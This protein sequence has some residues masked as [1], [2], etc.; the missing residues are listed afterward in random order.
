MAILFN[1]LRNEGVF[2]QKVENH[3]FA[4]HSP[5]MSGVEQ[6]LTTGAKELGIRPNRRT[7]RWIS[8]T[9]KENEWNDPLCQFPSGEYFAKNLCKPVLFYDS[10][11]RAPKNCL[12]IEI[13]PSALLRH[14]IGKSFPKEHNIQYREVLRRDNNNDNLFVLLST[15][16]Q[17]YIS[18]QNIDVK[19]LY[20]KV[21]YPVPRG[22]DFI[23]PLIRWDH[24]RSHF[25]T[26]Y[27]DYFSP[28]K[29]K[30]VQKYTISTIEDTYLS[31]HKIDGR[32]LYPGVGYVIIAWK[33]MATSLGVNDLNELPV[34]F[35]NVN[36]IQA[37]NLTTDEIVLSCSYSKERHKFTVEVNNT[38]VSTGYLKP[39]ENRNELTVEDKVLSKSDKLFL[40]GNDVYKEFRVRGYDYGPSFQGI[41]RLSADGCEAQVKWTGNLI[42][43]MDSIMQMVLLDEF[44]RFL[45]VPNRIE[46]LKMDPKTL[47]ADRVNSGDYDF[48]AD[49]VFD[50]NIIEVKTNGL[51]MRNIGLAPISRKTTQNGELVLEKY[52]L[53]PYEEKVAIDHELTEKIE[54]YSKQ[55]D[56]CIEKFE[57]SRRELSLIENNIDD[58]NNDLKVDI[59]NNYDSDMSEEE[60]EL[61]ENGEELLKSIKYFYSRNP[62][63]NSRLMSELNLDNDLIQSTL[64]CERFLRSSVD[65]FVENSDLTKK[66]SVLEV[67]TSGQVFFPSIMKLI[68]RT[69]PGSV[70]NNVEYTLCH[71]NRQLLAQNI[72]DSTRLKIIQFDS[73]KCVIPYQQLSPQ[74][75]IVFRDPHISLTS[76][77]KSVLDYELLLRSMETALTDGGF[78]LAFLRDDILDC[79]LR[80]T[81]LRGSA[82]RLNYQKFLSAAEEAGLQ[83]VC[84]KSDS[85][86][87]SSILFRKLDKTLKNET[88]IH[89]TYD[90]LQWLEPLK[91]AMKDQ[92]LDR[93]W[94][95]TDQKLNGITGLVKGLQKEENGWKVRS[96]FIDGRPE[97]LESVLKKAK[98]TDLVQNVFNGKVWGSYR[99]IS[100]PEVIQTRPINSAQ[101]RQ[102]KFGDLSSFKWSLS[103][104]T[105]WPLTRTSNKQTLID[106][107]YSPLNF[108]DVMHATGRLPP[109]DLTQHMSWDDVVLGLEFVGR[110]R[111]TGQRVMGLNSSKALSTDI[112]VDEDFLWSVPDSWSMADAATV[113]CVYA[114]AYYA[115]VIRGRL[116]SGETVLIHAG[117]GGVGQAAINICLS[118]NCRVFTTVGTQEKRQWIRKRFPQMSDSCIAS[119]RDVSFE[120][121]IMKETNGRGVDIILNSLTDQMFWSSVRCLAN[122]GR[123]CEIG[124]YQ[125]VNN[126][127][128]DTSLLLRNKTFH[129]IYLDALFGGLNNLVTKKVDRE[130]Q[131]MWRLVRDGIESG[132]VRPLPQ[133]L[134]TVEETESA[135]RFMASG[136]HIGKVVVQ[137]RPEEQNLLTIA[138]PMTVNAIPL[139]FFSP[140][141]SYVIT[142]GL[143]GMG[144]E[145]MY[146]MYERNARNFVLTS[147]S[148]VKT[149]TQEYAINRLKERN[150][151]IIVSTSDSTDTNGAEEVLRTA[152]GL[153]P[154]GGIFLLTLVLE[155]DLI[156][157]QTI[158]KFERVLN[159]KS[160]QALIFDRLVRQMAEPLDHFVAFSSCSCGRGITG[161]T[162]YGFANSILERICDQR[163]ADG[164]PG[165]AIQWGFVGDVGVAADNSDEKANRSSVSL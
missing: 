30:S 123:F 93:I 5:L 61:K 161:Q 90:C 130:R 105:L 86:S 158:E 133:T 59:N 137:I 55:C 15:L 106:V 2:H 72:L 141:K 149:A 67:S 109:F 85:F 51:C 142:G 128:L 37:T 71:S 148:G 13:G 29:S 38:V 108:K 70:I 99:H 136:K 73:N 125:F 78:L 58:N 103:P 63:K 98:Q 44:K 97:N 57:K 159:A 20:T 50:K 101:V 47:Y 22:T 74:N 151:K 7:N 35:W 65:I 21:E 14:S 17:L 76:D 4:A 147:R 19:K 140:S 8:T 69:A 52:E 46:S 11:V 102:L 80:F 1:N 127:D 150:C 132:V 39:L 6:T 104:N 107:Y 160:T 3:G 126:E 89:I 68:G 119:S 165:L 152:Q 84:R 144:L 62:S 92:T 49:V 66:L 112:I 41:T 48:T 18:G 139:T 121:R 95:T 157:N 120:E 114:T 75:L 91:T 81:S 115:L 135:F 100:L 163:R 129:G 33:T 64:L 124:K 88:Q 94:L 138:K 153:G 117:T 12:F 45:R 143:G 156:E 27:P 43:Y 34:H 25:V 42:S 155:D 111:D 56:F 77:P 28:K 83:Y 36:L 113:P 162:N 60:E 118:L 79:Q 23:S 31:D 32:V 146:W 145:L 26:K 164:L 10:L 131:W 87:F 40:T 116:K 54:L 154:I 96:V 53:I 9:F 122:N 82:L 134:F 16:G 24:R 110:R